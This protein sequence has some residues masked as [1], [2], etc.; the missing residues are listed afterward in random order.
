[1]E[2]Y[3]HYKNKK[4]YFKLQDIINKTTDKASVLYMDMYNTLYV[5][6][7]DDFYSK[8]DLIDTNN[9]MEY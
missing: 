3:K 8:F 9:L 1:M 5:R 2:I 7:K 6:D 4:I